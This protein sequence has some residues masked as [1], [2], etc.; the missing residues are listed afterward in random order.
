M[1]KGVSD[2]ISSVSSLL[3]LIGSIRGWKILSILFFLTLVGLFIETQVGLLSF[4]NLE[5]RAGLLKELNSLAQNGVTQNNDL[6]PIYQNL[7]GELTRSGA[8]PGLI[9]SFAVGFWKFFSGASFWFGLLVLALLVGAKPDKEGITLDDSM[10][11]LVMLGIFFGVVG[12]FLP[13]ISPLLNY[14]GFPFAQVL[15]FLIF[16]WWWKRKQGR[17]I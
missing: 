7:V 14:L 1:L 10:T 4:W 3:S 16:S 13:F 12:V 17:A 5:R 15:L 2:F 8:L 6:N 11:G 9:P